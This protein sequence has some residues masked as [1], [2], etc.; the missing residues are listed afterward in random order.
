MVKR[1]QIEYWREYT[2]L[3]PRIPIGGDQNAVGTFVL[4]LSLNFYVIPTL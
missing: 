4:A 1:K 2:R 3:G